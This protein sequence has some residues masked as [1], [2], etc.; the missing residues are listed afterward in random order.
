MPDRSARRVRPSRRSSTL[1]VGVSGAIQHKVGMQNS[2]NI[3]AIN[4]DPNAP[5]FEFSD[6]GIVG[7]LNKIMPKS[8]PRPSRPRRAESSS[9]RTAGERCG[10]HTAPQGL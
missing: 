2:E 10:C 8:S 5:I 4:K 9:N 3:V 1:A 6:L 7:D